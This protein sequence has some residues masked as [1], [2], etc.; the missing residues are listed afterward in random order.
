MDDNGPFSLN[1]D[2][3]AKDPKAFQEA[4][5]NDEKR[6]ELLQK[7]P[8]VAKVALGDDMQAFQELLKEAYRAEKKNIEQ[9]DQDLFQRGTDAQRA[10]ARVPQDAVSLYASMRESG[11]QYGPAFQLLQKVHV[12]TGDKGM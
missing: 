6:M 1:E 3:T 7:E 5:R 4:L 8:E 10:S 11:L 2:G 9:R 12:S